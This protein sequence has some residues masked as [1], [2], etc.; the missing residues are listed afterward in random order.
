MGSNADNFLN[1][2]LPL[3]DKVDGG[4]KQEEGSHMNHEERERYY[5][6]ARDIDRGLDHE[7]YRNL[8]INQTTWE[9]VFDLSLRPKHE[10]LGLDRH[11]IEMVIRK[12][13]EL[14]G[15]K[16]EADGWWN[17]FRPILGKVQGGNKQ[18]ERIHINHEERERYYNAARDIDRGLENDHYRNLIINQTTWEKVFELS[19]RPKHEG[20]GLDRH[21][22]EMVIRKYAEL[23]GQKHEAD[24][25]W[26][27]FRP[28]LDKVQG[29]N[30]QEE[31]EGSHIDHDSK[32]RY[33]NAAK[34][35]DNWFENRDNYKN[36]LF[37]QTTWE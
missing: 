16:D 32:E 4:N 30:K 3:L 27:Y 9:K 35:I 15:A 10:G 2:Y 24:G 19:L 33:W 37:A 23:S 34:A 6:A 21:R 1:T 29:G 20:L 31:E 26:S 36:H 22:I 11:R 14:S 13:A 5:N 7:H 12:F 8:I 18:E 28:I 17:H 25:W